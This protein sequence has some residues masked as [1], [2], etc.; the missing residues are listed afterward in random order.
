M[1]RNNQVSRIYRILNILEGA[2][3]G[4]TAGDLHGR[5]SSRGFEYDKRTVYRD[6]EAIK[7]AGF[8]LDIKGEDENGG[9]RWAL[10]KVSKVSS[11]LVFDLK[12]LFGFFLAKSLMT[13]LD[14]APFKQDLGTAFQKI[15]EKLSDK[16]KS[17]L[18]ELSECFIFDEYSRWAV[19]VNGEMFYTVLSAC[20]EKHKLKI[21]HE[22]PETGE[23]HWKVLGPQHIKLLSGS[24]FLVAEVFDEKEIRAFCLRRVSKAF[25]LAEPYATNFKVD[26]NE[27]SSSQNDAN[28]VDSQKVVL[29]FKPPVNSE[30]LQCKRHAS[31]HFIKK[32]DGTVEVHY[33]MRIDASFVYW[34]LSHGPRVKILEPRTLIDRVI[35]Q[36]NAITKIY[37]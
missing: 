18:S 20:F 2:P 16:K 34:V 33:N 24:V 37:E 26:S 23:I 29:E 31:Q 27:R 4:L 12:E 15:E 36:A 7:K 35:N 8:P 19:G 25:M 13:I 5:L 14:E 30:V 22:D 28:L 9:K 6:L 17:F 10:D 11:Q 3:Q 21:R 32:S 1:A